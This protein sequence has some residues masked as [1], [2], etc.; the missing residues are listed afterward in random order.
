MTDTTEPNPLAVIGGN[1]PPVVDPE[2]LAQARAKADEFGAKAKEWKDLGKIETKDQAEKLADFVKGARDV[3]KVIDGM[4]VAAK[5]PHDDAATKVQATFKPLLDG[6]AAMVEAL[7]PMQEA[8]LKAEQK[9]IAEEQAVIAREAEAKRVAAEQEAAAAEQR[10]DFV[11]A[12]EQQAAAEEATKAVAKAEKA[13]ASPKA[14]VGSASG[15]GKAIG[16]KRYPK[17]EITNARLAALHFLDNPSLRECITQLALAAARSAGVEALQNGELTIP[18][19]T[20]SIEE[21]L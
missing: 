1:N 20:L 17:A 3:S 16:L 10:G 14:S 21:R 19:I 11:G 7:K 6:I 5:K 18:G 4:R 2:M 9:R 15:A 13:A 12:A 8:W